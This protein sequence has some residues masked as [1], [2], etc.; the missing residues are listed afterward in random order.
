MHRCSFDTVFPFCL[1]RHG[2]ERQR[3]FA[4]VV[5]R[6]SMSSAPDCNLILDQKLCLIRVDIISLEHCR[7]VLES[8]LLQQRSTIEFSLLAFGCPI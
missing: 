3:L 5:P 6:A 8:T 1:G 7:K 2:I 4:G